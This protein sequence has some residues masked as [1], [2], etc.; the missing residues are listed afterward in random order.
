MD[1]EDFLRRIRLAVKEFYAND[2][3]RLVRLDADHLVGL[4]RVLFPV[5]QCLR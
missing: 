2:S 1:L 5:E 4:S 3:K